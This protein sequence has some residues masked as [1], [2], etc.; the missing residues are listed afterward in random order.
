MS[1]VESL[2]KPIFM[3]FHLVWICSSSARFSG[4][5]PACHTVWC[6]S[7]VLLLSRKNLICPCRFSMSKPNPHSFLSNGSLNTLTFGWWFLYLVSYV[8]VVHSTFSSF[9]P[10]LL[11]LLSLIAPLALYF[12]F[13]IKVITKFSKNNTTSQLFCPTSIY[14]SIE[15][16]ARDYLRHNFL[17]IIIVIL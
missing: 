1:L 8:L 4:V 2:T 9:S 3:I 10:T 7:D 17:I 6:R 16:L 13:F 14:S 15:I 5:Y 11:F 12:L